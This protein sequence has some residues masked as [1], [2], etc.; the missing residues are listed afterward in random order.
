MKYPVYRLLVLFTGLLAAPCARAQVCVEQVKAFA[1]GESIGYSVYY[2]LAGVYFNAGNARFTTQLTHLDNKPVFWLKGEG[3]SNKNY[4]WIFKVRDQY[5]SY[6]DSATMQP[7]K[8][9][10]NISEGK[11][12]KYENVTFNQSAHTAVTNQGVYTITSCTHDVISIVYAMRNIP[13]HSFKTGDTIPF[14]LFMD[15]QLYGLYIRYTGREVLKTRHGK[16]NTL[17]LKPL[18]IKGSLFQGG[19]QMDVWITDDEN[20][21]PVRIQTPITVG[22]IKV[23]LT[24][25]THL[26]YPLAAMI[27][28]KTANTE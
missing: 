14:H 1:P 3:S 28:K 4:D 17:R 9:V 15:N 13:F 2:S 12:R 16:F 8:F 26:R 24:E 20:H 23:D 5:E 22:K 21:I 11:Y 27:N 10:R 25:Y 6:I 18:L 7:C 19:E